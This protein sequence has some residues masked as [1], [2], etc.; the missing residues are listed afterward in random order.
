MGTTIGARC[1]RREGDGSCRLMRLAV[2]NAICLCCGD[3][4]PEW[5]SPVAQR[6]GCAATRTMSLPSARLRAGLRCRASSAPGAVA[7]SRG[8]ARACHSILRWCCCARPFAAQKD[9]CL[10][11]VSFACSLSS[12][13][14]HRGACGRVPHLL[15]LVR[16]SLVA[17]NSQ[18][19]SR[20]P[21]PPPGA[22][23]RHLHC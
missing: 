3:C 22:S 9:Y 7:V 2:T 5:R 15:H 14:A 1:R 6:R 20:G 23:G 18:R 10:V 8:A 16:T 12:Q 17:S 21:V 13:A 19:C 11:I 4:S